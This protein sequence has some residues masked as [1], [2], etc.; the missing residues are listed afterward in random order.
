[1][2]TFTENE[3]NIFHH[4][5]RIIISGYSN[6]GKSELVHQLIK[7]YH[8]LFKKILICGIPHHPLQNHP[9]ISNKLFISPNI[10][11]P[12][13][14]NDPFDS[15]G[16]LFI[17]DDCFIE[18]TKNE[19]VVDAFI[20]GRHSNIST[21]LVTQNLFLSGKHSRNISLNTSHFILLRQRD[22]AQIQCL[23]R[24]LFGAKKSSAFVD[25]YKQVVFRKPY[26]YILIDLSI[27]TPECLQFRSNI[28]G[29]SPGELVFQWTNT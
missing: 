10:I 20:K 19:I 16:I 6:S 13:D 21:I 18:A 4:P 7:K 2:E 22:I 24:Q 1:M 5:A 14:N 8:H 26:S 25:I 12:L 29:E 9:D 3:L 15:K 28:V 17:L 11:N 23:A 27:N